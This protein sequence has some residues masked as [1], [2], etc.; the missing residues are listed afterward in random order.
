MHRT[1]SARLAPALH[2]Q[3][4]VTKAAGQETQV[5]D[6]KDLQNDIVFKP[7]EEVRAGSSYW[8]QLVYTATPNG[9]ATAW[10]HGVFDLHAGAGQG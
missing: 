9:T 7:F 2:R 8:I 4:F 6:K 5:A 10:D 3:Q 1:L